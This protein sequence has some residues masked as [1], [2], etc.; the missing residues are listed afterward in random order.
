MNWTGGDNCEATALP[1]GVVPNLGD[2]STLTGSFIGYYFPRCSYVAFTTQPVGVSNAPAFK[3]VT[4]T[5]NGTTDSQ[6][7]IMGLDYP[8]SGLTNFVFFQWYVN[9]TAVPGAITSSFT[10]TALPWQQNAQVMCQMTAVGLANAAGTAVWSNSLTAV[11]NVSTNAAVPAVAYASIFQGNG[12]VTVLDIRFSKPMDPSTLLPTSLGGPATYTISGFDQ[13]KW[14]AINI[15]TN[16]SLVS[17]LSPTSEVLTKDIYGSIQIGL[18]G[19]P[20]YP[21]S[22]SVSGVKDAWEN[23]MASANGSFSIAGPAQLSDTDSGQGADPIVP[24]VLWV[25]GPN[26]FTIQCEGS[27]IWGNADGFNFAY[28]QLTGDFDVV[29]RV[30][31]IVHT[32]EWT[33]SGLMV[34]ETLDAASRNWNIV[35]DPVTSDGIAGQ[36]GNGNGANTIEANCRNSTA[37]ASAGWATGYYSEPPQYPNAWLRLKRVGTDLYCYYS[38]DGVHWLIRAHDNPSVVGDAIA[39]PATV[40]V[41]L[42][43][44]AHSNDANPPPAWTS[45]LFL[46]TTDYADY[47]AAY[48]EG[49]AVPATPAVVAGT[50]AIAFASFY[51]NNNLTTGPAQMIDIK[52]NKPMDPVSMGKASS[53]VLPAGLTITAVNVYAN[54]SSGVSPGSDAIANNYSSVLLTVTG[55]PTLPLAITVNGVSDY[56]G[57]AL[58]SPNNTATAA[59]CPLINQDIGSALGTDPV[60]PSTM[61]VNGTNSYSI[62]SEGSDIWG[63]ADGFNFTYTTLSGDFDVVVR[64]KDTTHTSNWS[65]AGLMVRET[66]D[67]AS[68][69]WNI[70]NDPLSSDGI[71]ALDGSG[72]GAS[73]I[74][75]N[76]RNATAGAS[77]GWQV[78]SNSAA[79][80]YPNAW[81][82]L[83]RTGTT[84]AAFHSTDGTDWVQC[85]YDDPSK[86]GTGGALPANV[87]VGVCQTA[88][89]ND[90]TP[91]APFA[92]LAFLDTADYDSLN[93]AYTL[94]VTT[95][96]PLT[97][98]RSGSNVII[99]WTPAGG[100][101]Q[102][103]PAIGTAANWQPVA[104]QANPMTVPIGSGNQYFRLKY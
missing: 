5:A 29:V 26:S 7:G 6:I 81:V 4:F 97:L 54:D 68:R 69:D 38:N 44:Q 8:E 45:L 99:S 33:K 96:A 91:L 86:V 3:P 65:K 42:A 80:V 103:S 19:T 55:T 60:V 59:L 101:L 30:K 104:N 70:V 82:R 73:A 24:G 52:F 90:P 88:H 87:F 20:S 102:S 39:L 9:G 56:W 62:Q 47:N 18:F 67:A 95:Q 48:V 22:V 34:R 13:S 49:P 35:N 75:C 66:L 40:Y 92:N 74:E 78:T 17:K 53:Y 94:V 89:N 71:M 36:D 12:G 28:Q 64:V 98:K 84:L 83:K 85:A 37:G 58:A 11:L 79:P 41:G 57:A 93:L 77:A 51:T 31:D 1:F 46:N 15:F 61:W 32:S 21:V 27:D 76:C 63:N 2:A 72:T 100:T 14:G 50:P 43:Q 16:G 25:N 10:T 23:A